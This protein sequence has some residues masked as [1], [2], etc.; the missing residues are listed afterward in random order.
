MLARSVDVRS[1]TAVTLDVLTS[2]DAEWKE[3]SPI[4]G[5]GAIGQAATAVG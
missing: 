4:F 2:P 1:A 3:L 5:D